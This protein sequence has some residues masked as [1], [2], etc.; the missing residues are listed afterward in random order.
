MR[1]LDSCGNNWFNSSLVVTTMKDSDQVYFYHSIETVK[2]FSFQ[3]S[4]ATHTNHLVSNEQSGFKASE[5]YGK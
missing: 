4:I 2:Q 3:I 5:R 1:K